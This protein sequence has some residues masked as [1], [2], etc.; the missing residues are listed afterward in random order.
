MCTLLFDFIHI[1]LKYLNL[2]FNVLLSLRQKTNDK[3]GIVLAK[4]IGSLPPVISL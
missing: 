4:R 1:E 3:I 2:T